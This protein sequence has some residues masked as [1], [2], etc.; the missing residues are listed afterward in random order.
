MTQF[1]L[2]FKKSYV[3]PFFPK[4]KEMRFFQKNRASSLLSIYDPLTSCKK[5]EKTNEPIPRIVRY[6]RTNQPTNQPTNAP[7]GMN[8]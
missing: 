4:N 5:L 2:K 8:L 7:T 1:P 3:D 6:A